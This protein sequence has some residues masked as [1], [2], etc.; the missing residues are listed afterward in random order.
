M[1]SLPDE[2]V[3]FAEISVFKL[4]EAFDRVLKAAQI[5]GPHEVLMDRLSLSDAIGGIAERLQGGLQLSFR[6]LFQPLVE[7]ERSTPMDRHR[8]VVTFA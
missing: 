8:L 1:E 5:K 2:E 7:G 3:G 6:S 4:I